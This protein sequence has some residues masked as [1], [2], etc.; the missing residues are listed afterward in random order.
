MKVLKSGGYRF[1]DCGKNTG[2]FDTAGV[3]LFT[4]DVVA[5]GHVH[6]EK[7]GGITCYESGAKQ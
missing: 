2:L 5:I 7:N 1:G 4:G 3:E 6:L